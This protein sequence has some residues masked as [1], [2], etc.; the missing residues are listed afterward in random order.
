MPDGIK[1]DMETRRCHN[2]VFLEFS[3][4]N[5]TYFV[6]INSN[7]KVLLFFC[8]DSGTVSFKDEHVVLICLILFAIFFGSIAI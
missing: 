7:K 5:I 1:Q 2:V 6:C 8:N 3:S 4:T